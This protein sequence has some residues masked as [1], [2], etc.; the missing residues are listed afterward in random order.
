MYLSQQQQIILE[1][2][3]NNQI[4]ST[5]L[6]ELENW[7]EAEFSEV[8]TYFTPSLETELNI[9]F[10]QEVNKTKDT[11]LDL[12]EDKLQK[13]YPE[14]T[15]TL[16]YTYLLKKL[17]DRIKKT[18]EHEVF[19]MRQLKKERIQIKNQ[20]YIP[21]ITKNLLRLNKIQQTNL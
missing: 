7:F 1:T 5:T 17:K 20:Q 14:Q 15:D 16:L 10:T 12:L 6:Q 8:N 13:E 9:R 18:S 3:T 19:P 4:T 2:L 11:K 21:I